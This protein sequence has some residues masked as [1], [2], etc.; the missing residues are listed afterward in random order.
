MLLDLSNL[1]IRLVK[2]VARCL[3]CSLLVNLLFVTYYMICLGAQ[4]CYIIVR[5]VQF[6]AHN[7]II[8]IA[9]FVLM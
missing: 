5:S 1:L 8:H 3:I 9:R 6:A 7:F 4:I 2:F